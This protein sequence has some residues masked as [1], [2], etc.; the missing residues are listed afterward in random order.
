MTERLARVD[1]LVRSRLSPTTK[2]TKSTKGSEDK[3]PHLFL[4]PYP[5]PKPC[6]VIEKRATCKPYQMGVN[7][8][9]A[10]G[11]GRIVGS[12]QFDELRYHCRAKPN[13]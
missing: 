5:K 13:V 3:A 10:R 12:K 1:Q 9:N 7:G 6:V 4:E 8:S 2:D 11:I